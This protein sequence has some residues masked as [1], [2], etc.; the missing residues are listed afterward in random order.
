MRI[1]LDFGTTN[2]GAALYDG[3][4]VHLFSL[5]PDS[6]SPAVMRSVM[7]VTRDQQFY[8]GQRAIETYYSQNVGRPSRLI[9]QYVG[10]IEMAF[11]EVG[12]VKGYPAS[13]PT[14]VR[15]VYV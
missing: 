11:A 13:L 2:S 9:Q 7:Y 1:G 14:I 8:C 10:E 6:S 12:A 3:G 15:E 4:R 5:E